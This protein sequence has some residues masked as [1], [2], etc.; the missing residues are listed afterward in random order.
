MGN[1]TEVI[2]IPKL[3]DLMVVIV[4]ISTMIIQI[5]PFS[6]LTSSVMVIAMMMALTITLKSVHT[7]K[8]TVQR[9][10]HNILNAQV[11]MVGLETVNATPL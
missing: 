10:R 5:V 9:S 7:M 8:T 1:V 11:L 6:T 4:L 3:A 2:I